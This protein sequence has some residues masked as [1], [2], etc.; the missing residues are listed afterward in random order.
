MS[1]DRKK[2]GLKKRKQNKTKTKK[3][4]SSDHFQSASPS[5]L[6]LFSLSLSIYIYIYIKQQTGFI[7]DHGIFFLMIFMCRCSSVLVSFC[8]SGSKWYRNGQ[9][10]YPCAFS[11]V[12]I[13]TLGFGVCLV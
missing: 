2:P 13:G 12:L 5:S 11:D 3:K 8:L 10:F 4:D 7:G 1:T 6:F 9:Y